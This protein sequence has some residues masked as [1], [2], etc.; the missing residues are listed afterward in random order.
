AT[1]GVMVGVVTAA[2]AVR[3]W[4]GYSFATWRFHL[5]GLAISS[6]EDVAWINELLV[7]PMMR[8]D[9]PVI[10]AEL[11]LDGLHRRFPAGSVRNVFV[12]DDRGRLSGLIDPAE[13]NAGGPDGGEKI[14]KLASHPVPFL[15]PNDNLR[16]A[17]DRFSQTAQETLAVVDNAEDR[18]IIGYLSEAY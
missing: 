5:R 2:I 9:P 18:R 14:G 11:S 15:L 17:L 16:T 4:F 12:V 6:P 8:R 1:I 13:A 3:H 7:G 10:A